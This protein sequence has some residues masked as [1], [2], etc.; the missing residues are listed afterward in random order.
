MSDD[1]NWTR[2][3]PRVPRPPG[4]PAVFTI[5]H[6]YPAELI[7]EWCGISVASA[8]LYKVSKR[9]PSKAVAKLFLLHRD[10]RVLGP[11]WQDWIVKPD[12]I[13]D[14]DGNETSRSLLHNYFWIVQFARRLA[15]DR[16]D[17]ARAEFEKLLAG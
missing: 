15:Y 11:Q 1:D 14:P 6:G 7:A 3:P 9:K 5:F 10:R 16:E 4:P 8:R 2:P 13:V 12:S 17:G